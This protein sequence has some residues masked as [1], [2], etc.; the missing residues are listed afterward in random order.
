MI[1]SRLVLGLQLLGHL[2]SSLKG[3]I[4]TSLDTFE[5]GSPRQLLRLN[6][7]TTLCAPLRIN[8]VQ[9]LHGQKE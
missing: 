9:K 7:Q 8:Q 1:G 5:A 6:V 2:H 3:P 4:L